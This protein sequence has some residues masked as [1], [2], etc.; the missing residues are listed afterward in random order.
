M[1]PPANITESP[2]PDLV[3]DLVRFA[4]MAWPRVHAHDVQSIALLSS[5]EGEG[6][7]T[8]TCLLGQVLAAHQGL[9]VLLADGNARHPALADLAGV[10]NARGWRD[11]IAA[12]P[13][14]A[15]IPSQWPN[16][17]V[18]PHGPA[19]SAST[20]T[21]VTM[22]QGLLERCK[23]TFDVTLLDCAPLACMGDALQVARLA[24]AA[25]LVVEAD[26][27]SRAALAH[28]CATLES[29]DLHFLG[30]LLNRHRYPVPGF[31]YRR[32]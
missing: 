15:C 17:A 20:H 16:V 23:A 14:T 25:I 21:D 26:R 5:V 27:M 24:D 29:L 6:T 31:L 28:S 8:V 3:A 7:T 32:A 2:Q 9:Q 13:Q 11:A 22:L 1:A 12:G 10:D 19:Q 4:A 30:V 18:C